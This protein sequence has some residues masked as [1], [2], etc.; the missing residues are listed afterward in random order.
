MSSEIFSTPPKKLLFVVNED[1]AFLSHFLDRAIAAKQRGYSVGLATKCTR[2]TKSI[3]SYGI[4]VFPIGMSRKGLNPLKEMLVIFRLA[5][6]YRQFR[7]DIVH[8]VALKPIVVGTFASLVLPGVHVINAPI[9]MGYAYTSRDT[10][11][12]LIRVLLN[13]VL[14][15][16]IG[17]RRNHVIIENNDDFA[18]LVENKFVKNSKISLIRGAGVDISEFNFRIEPSTTTVVTLIARMLRDKGIAEF[19]GAASLLKKK[20]PDTTFRLVGDI[21]N[22]NPASFSSE[23]LQ[24]WQAGGAIEWLGQRD[25]IPK[26]I[27]ESNIVC[28][29]S[30]R[31]GLPKTLIEA[32]A[33]GRAIVATDVPGCR[34]VVEHGV[35]GLLVLPRDVKSLANAL[36]I[37]ILDPDLRSR[38]GAAG[39]KRAETEFS[40]VLI[41]EQT[42][43]VYALVLA[44]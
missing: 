41:N 30:Y 5:S 23:N 24:N 6:I 3:E 18:W 2:E 42:L 4:S 25:D 43:K 27:G 17:A 14:K 9:G 38:M 10:K 33:I 12:H 34:E 21:D 22:G 44:Q 29:P 1:W 31:E 28:L 37:L 7:P 20:F 39:R 8:H 36:E 11:A 16:L 40:S 13:F 15:R 32:A 35:N 19:V 26:I